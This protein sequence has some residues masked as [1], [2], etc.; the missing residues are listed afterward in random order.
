MHFQK[1]TAWCCHGKPG[2]LHS[3]VSLW[4]TSRSQPKEDSWQITLLGDYPA[5]VMNPRGLWADVCF[6]LCQVLDKSS[7]IKTNQSEIYSAREAWE[8]TCNQDSAARTCS[9]KER[10]GDCICQGEEEWK[11]FF[12]SLSIQLLSSAF[13]KEMLWGYLSHTKVRG[14][15]CTLQP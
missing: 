4:I 11:R 12:A 14:L 9:R 1:Q 2:S 15:L 8:A 5:F 13:L 10:N 7:P 6:L 3:M